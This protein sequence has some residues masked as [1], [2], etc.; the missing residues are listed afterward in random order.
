MRIS[1]IQVLQKGEARKR[2]SNELKKLIP[3]LNIVGI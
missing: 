3:F 2:D 1:I